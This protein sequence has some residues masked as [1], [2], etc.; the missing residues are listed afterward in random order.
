MFDKTPIL[1]RLVRCTILPVIFFQS[2]LTAAV[3][4]AEA[5][6][7][8]AGEVKLA[9][10][11]TAGYTFH[12][13][14]NS[15]RGSLRLSD[16]LVALTSSGILLRFELP[17]IKLV[18]ERIGAEEITC[19][20]R[21]EGDTVFAGI[22][23]GRICRVD[24]MS[25]EFTDFAR[26]HSAP[27]WIGWRGA[28]AK[29]PAGLLA[30]TTQ[31]KNV[32]EDGRR[33]SVPVSAVHDLAKHTAL[34]LEQQ[35]TTYLLD[36]TGWLWLGADKG[37]WGGWVARVD[38]SNGSVIEVKPPLDPAAKD[39]SSW[40]GVYGFVERADG[41]VW[42]YGGTSHM[43]MNSSFI[44]RVDQPAPVRL[45]SCETPADTNNQLDP[46]VP[47]MP[48]THVIADNGGLLV[49]SYSDVFRADLALKSWNKL[50]VLDIAYR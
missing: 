28:A 16:G 18:R 2:F 20:G 23:D 7:G 3:W 40:E 27:Q 48:I 4:G 11:R 22:S 41:Q 29:R 42:A 1:P 13:D 17:A 49:L 45:F 43:G 19:I 10:G 8:S 32:E 36:R 6:I 39:E 25:L 47:Y 12:F 31:S 14:H 33:F 35:A 26:L 15:L 24:P 46:H 30:L 37:E 34:V 44:T 50:A 5:P 38:T 21:V 9:S